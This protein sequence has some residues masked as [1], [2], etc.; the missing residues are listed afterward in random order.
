MQAFLIDTHVWLWMVEGER[1][2]F[3]EEA[4]Q[5]LERAAQRNGLAVSEASFWEVALKAGKG[6]LEVMPNARAWL[7]RASKTPGIGIVQLDRDILVDSTE[8]DVA[9]RDPAD[10]MLVATALKYDLILATADR[11]LLE[12]AERHPGLTAFDVTALP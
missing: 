6:S 7:R 8:L 4:R 1:A 9:T 10:R 2:K 5:A 11:Q 3:S 12:F